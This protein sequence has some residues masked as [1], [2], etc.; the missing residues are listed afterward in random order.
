M[1]KIP[2]IL[3]LALFTN[4]V[5]AE[6]V[7]PASV[8]QEECQEIIYSKWNDLLLVNNGDKQFVAY[9]WYRDHVAMDGETRQYLYTQG[10][11]LK[12]DGHVYHVVATTADGH[13]VISCEGTFE[14]FP[15]STSFNSG[16]ISQAVLF[17]YT[18][19]KVGEWETQP[20]N[21]SVSPGI[22]VWVL[23]DTDGY[24]WTE[25]AVF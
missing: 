10:V 11:V 17:T 12:S 8:P 1:K 16:T 23:T 24:T 18:G 22:Y 5:V 6:G 20:T 9:Q 19:R 14:E 7:T 2:V 3:F 13:Q 15:R 4:T 21:V 25:K